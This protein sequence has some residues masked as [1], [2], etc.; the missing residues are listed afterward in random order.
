MMIRD[1]STRRRVQSARSR[2]QPLDP[3]SGSRLNVL[4]KSLTCQNGSCLNLLLICA[5]RFLKVISDR[6]LRNHMRHLF[7]QAANSISNKIV[8]PT[9]FSSVSMHDASVHRGNVPLDKQ[10]NFLPKSTSISNVSTTLRELRHISC[11]GNSIVVGQVVSPMS[12]WHIQPKV[13][14]SPHI[15]H[16]WIA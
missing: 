1:N 4:S 9:S 3:F 14:D 16:I 10:V 7:F 5:F 8:A 15:G 11:P 6:G 13:P 12:Q 2:D